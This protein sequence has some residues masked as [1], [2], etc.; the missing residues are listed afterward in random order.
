[1]FKYNARTTGSNYYFL[2][3]F[4]RLTSFRTLSAKRC[5]CLKRSSSSSVPKTNPVFHAFSSFITRS[6]TTS[7]FTALFSIISWVN[8]R[9]W[10]VCSS[11]NLLHDGFADS[12]AMDGALEDI[13]RSIFCSGDSTSVGGSKF[14][15]NS[16]RSLL[17]FNTIAF[18]ECVSNRLEAPSLSLTMFSVMLPVSISDL[19]KSW[20]FEVSSSVHST[21]IIDT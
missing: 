12:D 9:R 4:W 8:D 19:N 14:L 18:M 15:V 17:T 3:I 6:E 7:L 2:F 5:F 16:D 1:M 13:N 20:S 21:G 11:V 10:S